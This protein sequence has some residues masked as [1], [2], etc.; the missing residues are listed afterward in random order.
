MNDDVSLFIKEDYILD[1]RTLI[2][3]VHPYGLGIVVKM[4]DL[5]E[6][7]NTGVI[8]GNVLKDQNLRAVS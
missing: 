6:K 3:D 5:Q 7:V 1:K 8:S 4:S 2:Y